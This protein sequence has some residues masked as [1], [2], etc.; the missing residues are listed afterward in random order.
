MY[1]A[2]MPERLPEVLGG[3]KVNVLVTI[4]NVPKNGEVGPFKGL[5]QSVHDIVFYS[6]KKNRTRVMISPDWLGV[7]GW[8]L[9]TE[10]IHINYF[11][12]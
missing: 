5:N 8:Y 11:D 9:S 6:R 12:F 7:R 2:G 3:G 10:H 4:A 1:L